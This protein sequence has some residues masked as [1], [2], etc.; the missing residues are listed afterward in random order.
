[1]VFFSNK[2]FIFYYLALVQVDLQTL[3]TIGA[4]HFEWVISAL[5][6]CHSNIPLTVGTSSGLHLYD[7]RSRMNVQSDRNEKVDTSA[8]GIF[9]P[10]PLPPYAPLPQS[11]P[12]GILHLE[13]PGQLHSVSDDIYVAGRFS[14]ILLFD[15][16]KFDRMVGSIYSGA[17][18]CSL[19]SFP[20]ATSTLDQDLRLSGSLTSEQVKRSKRANG[21]RT[22]IAGGEYNT[23]GSLELY[24]LQPPGHKDLQK[25]VFKNRQTAASSKILSVTTHGSRIA[26]SDSSGYIRWME[27]DGR[28]TVRKWKIGHSFS[29]TESS[30]FNTTHGTD[31]VARKLIVIERPGEN[32]ADLSNNNIVFWTGERLGLVKFSSKEGAMPFDPELDDMTEEEKELEEKERQQQQQM[33]RLLRSHANEV[34]FM[35]NLG[36]Q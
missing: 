34:R 7:Y 30:L 8:T 17:S 24:N 28:T 31:D 6:S 16:R 14:N 10:S 27:R 21:H 18:L 12:L 15:R 20:F 25:G 4:Q 1:M 35:Y 22:L 36:R 13:N 11:S 19:S 23:K 2:F 32:C 29:N 33:G 5:S 9:D 26:Y 3:K